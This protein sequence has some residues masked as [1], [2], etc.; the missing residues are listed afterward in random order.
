MSNDKLAAKNFD[1]QALS[2]KYSK[3]H[4]IQAQFAYLFCSFTVKNTT[5]FHYNM[6]FSTFCWLWFMLL[7]K[8]L[9]GGFHELQ[10]YIFL[11]I[12]HTG[13]GEAVLS[14]S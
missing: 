10:V 9:V 1:Q 13:D 5:T 2:V 7:C 6:F 8:R 12:L 4:P 14:R 3:N 11:D